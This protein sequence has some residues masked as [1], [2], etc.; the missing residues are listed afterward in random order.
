[1][2]ED[3]A[4]RFLTHLLA[5]P[6]T[7][8]EGGEEGVAESQD[9]LPDSAER[10]KALDPWRKRIHAVA[11]EEE[12]DRTLDA[13]K[14]SNL[15]SVDYERLYQEMESRRRLFQ[16]AAS[17]NAAD[18][19][20]ELTQVRESARETL[21]GKAAK[22]I[23]EA[24]TRKSSRLL[25][26]PDSRE[27]PKLVDIAVKE[28]DYN[29]R[30]LKRFIN[31]ASLLRTIL[32]VKGTSPDPDYERRLVV[33]GAHLVLNWPRIVRW[34]QGNQ[35]KYDLQGDRVKAS[36][37]LADWAR[38]P[39]LEWKQ[40]IAGTWGESVQEVVGNPRFYKFLQDLEKDPPGFPDLLGSP[41]FT[42]KGPH[43][44]KD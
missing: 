7:Q 17:V 37:C 29:P 16:V 8:V 43:P 36:Q 41:L 22:E 11:N 19:I 44:D 3:N 25:S 12:L 2:D 26:E 13:I 31:L 39:L 38:K 27:L 28:L 1:L 34:I 24:L 9:A 21:K 6:S 5:P 10:N 33:R 35:S 23:E 4:K 20:E 40:Q 14:G 42:C 32:A 15:S 30:T 18:S